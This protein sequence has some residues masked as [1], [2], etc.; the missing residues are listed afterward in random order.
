MS[1]NFTMLAQN[2]EVDYVQQAYLN[3]MSIRATNENVKI[4]LIQQKL[5]KN[6]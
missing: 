2:T 6:I 5:R 1:N 4:C 3:A